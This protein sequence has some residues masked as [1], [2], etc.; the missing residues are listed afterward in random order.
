MEAE[1]KSLSDDPEFEDAYWNWNLSRN[2]FLKQKTRPPQVWQKNYFRGV[3]P[4]TGEKE[5]T[6]RT[7]PNTPEFVDKQTTKYHVPERFKTDL[8]SSLITKKTEVI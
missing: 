1:I 4:H 2:K 5:E 6:H 3:H 8:E 7:K